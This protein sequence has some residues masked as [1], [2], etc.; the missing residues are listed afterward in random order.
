MFSGVRRGSFL[1]NLLVR[2]ALFCALLLATGP[3]LAGAWDTAVGAFEHADSSRTSLFGDASPF[4]A[5]RGDPTVQSEAD[6]PGL[7][8]V[9]IDGD[10]RVFALGG[11]LG[12]VASAAPYVA[13]LDQRTRRQLWRTPLPMVEGQRVWNYPGG[14]GIHANGFVYVAYAARMAKLDPVSGK[15]LAQLDLP[16]PNGLSD[17]SYNGFIVLSDGMILAKSHHR[18]PE[19]PVQG[20]RAFIICGVEGLPPSALAMIDPA[21]M[22]IVWNGRAEELIG[23]RITAT[24]FHGHEYVYL[25]GLD[26]LYRM[27]RDGNKLLA[28]RGWGPVTYR[29]GKETPGTAAIGFGDFVVIQTN[30]LPT[31]APM[32][33][34]AVSQADSAI[35]HSICPFEGAARRWSFTPSKASSDWA[36]RRIY[37][38]ESYGGFTALDFDPKKGFSI[39]WQA[40]Q[41]TGSFIT[42]LGET[43]NRVVV[44]SDIGLADSDEYGAPKHTRE[45]LV[46]RRASDGKELGRA[47]GLPRNFGLTLTP[48]RLGA[49]YYATGTKGLWYVTPPSGKTP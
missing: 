23:G 45:D 47:K 44:A 22:Q 48:T 19:C 9:A 42:L 36:A 28:D 2:S 10:G 38:S 25:A 7:W 27:R 5:S 17:T 15:V 43:K 3:A 20:Y 49:I 11:V 4:A 8:S 46:W 12:D 30:A 26:N 13:R 29:E 1:T 18:K 39:A 34:T 14:I 6:L 16:T 40:E 41:Y 32:R 24:R 35:R 37:T 33:L 31:T 21:K